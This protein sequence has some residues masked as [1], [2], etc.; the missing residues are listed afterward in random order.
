VSKSDP[1]ASDIAR[2]RDASEWLQ[3]LNGSNAQALADQWTQW[4]RSDPRNLP[5]FEQMQ[6]LWDA[7]PDARDTTLH[8]PQPA[9]RFKHRTGRI[10]LAASVVL[11][12]GMAGWLAKR[13][14]D[15]QVLDTPVG[16]Q[17]RITLADG[18]H[19]DLAPDSRVSTRFTPALR[20][21]QL[22]RGQAFFAVAHNVVRP[23]IVHVNSLTV[24][25]VGTA[26][27]VRMGPSNTVVTV[28]E[29][30]VNVA[31]AVKDAGGGPST[32]TE[33]VRAGVGHRVTFSKS[34]QR[35]SVATVDPKAAGS[36]RDGTLQFIGEPLED[37]VGA[38]NRYSAPQIVVAPA[39]Q[40]TRFTGT[41]S[42]TDVRD[43]LKALEQIYAVEVV[44]QGNNGIL[45]RSRAYD[46]ARK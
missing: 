6:R 25:A 5:A 10:A 1:T 39:F 24:T 42:P 35:L 2:L 4:C 20:D 34:A 31:G 32:G 40:Q 30:L 23:F 36:W 14:P 33:T 29:G 13:Y 3:R 22:E 26:F 16:E 9:T 7:F 8:P 44:D 37:V 17:R 46:V 45:I 11:L 15:V 21:V 43:W 28:S 41:V 19:L 18:S 38:V 12:V 27:D